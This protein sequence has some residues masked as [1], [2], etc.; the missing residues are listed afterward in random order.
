MKE[1]AD[2]LEKMDAYFQKKK[3]NERWVLV[4][5]PALMVGYLAWTLLYTPAQMAYDQSVADKVAVQK[6][7]KEDKDYLN[8]IT[9]NGDRDYRVKE[10]DR[11]IKSSKQHEALY[12]KKI[13]I[14]ETN[15]QKL[16]D[17]LFN[18]KSW[19]IFLDSIAVRARENNVE[20]IKIQNQFMDTN[21]SF[22]HVLEIGLYCQ[23]GFGGIVTFMNDLEQNTLVT[24]IYKSELF[25]D[26]NSTEVN[27]RINISVWGVNH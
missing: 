1:F 13:N 20:I 15:L 16:S 17:M 3:P 4:S 25:T 23:G 6:K 11:K 22:G 2:F 12:H 10:Y 27:A 19:S 24:D 26:N 21:G 5:I 18:Q 7:L 9:K 8:G 14:L